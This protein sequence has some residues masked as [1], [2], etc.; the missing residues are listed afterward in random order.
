[1]QSTRSTWLFAAVCS[2]VLAAAGDARA[3]PVPPV[4]DTDFYDDG[5]PP[6]ARVE[7]G[8]VLFFDKIL[9]GNLNISCAS[10]HHPMAGTGDGLA[11]S[12]GEGG[13]GL[14]VT[15]DTGYAEDAVHERVPRNAPPLF[16]LGAREFV[17]LFLDGRV[18]EDPT[19][20]SG[21]STPAGDDLPD[22]LDNVLAAQAMFSVANMVLPPPKPAA[23]MRSRAL[24]MWAHTPL[25]AICAA[26]E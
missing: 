15:R 4:V 16:N 2:L 20:P 7:L 1:M 12:V 9:S 5:A 10:C 17:R 24:P 23:A 14:G 13:R 8:R 26:V 11:L 19:A 21:F 6:T 18:E 3:G 22:G 25:A